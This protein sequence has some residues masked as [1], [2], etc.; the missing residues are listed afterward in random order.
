[1]NGRAPL[2]GAED[3][4]VA[5]ATPP[6]R[7]ALAIV[8]VSGRAAREIG[9]AVLDPFHWDAGRS[10]LTSLHTPGSTTT[11]D[12]VM[13]SVHVA[14]RSFTGED[15]VE[16]TTHGGS[17]VPALAF[18]ALIAAGARPALPGEF[19]RRAVANGKLDLLQAEAI[20]DLIEARSAVAHR[21]ALH[22]LDGGLTRRIS[23]LR[24]DVIALEALLAYEIDF[25]EEDEGP[26][27]RERATARSE[28]LLAAL[29][30]L[31]STAHTGEIVRE[32][33]IVVLAGAPNSGKSSLFNALVGAT[34]A[35]VTNVPGTTRDAL[36]AVVEMH[37]WPVRLVDTAGLRDGTADAVEKL[38]IEVAHRYVG[39]ANVVLVCSDDSAALP[40]AMK[41]VAGLSE[42]PRVGVRTKIDLVSMSDLKASPAGECVAVSAVTGQGLRDLT[43]AIAALLAA[44]LPPAEGAAGLLTRERHQRAV[45]RARAEVA[46]FREAWMSGSLPAPVAAVHLR[47]AADLLEELIGVVERNNVLDEVFRSFCIGK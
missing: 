21:S 33:A 38:G 22:Q 45:A 25:P 47:S 12:R 14:P 13:A 9:A 42:A 27:P 36:E 11:I 29:D 1:M 46:A 40:R 31:L 17:L 24:Q 8:R 44:G 43:G 18:D 6:G 41:Q 10:Y 4:I 19:S 23:A 28:A 16:L 39:R 30:R 15:T 3:T 37:G 35:I 26:T 5:L 2:P 20:A 7:S 34:R 32:G